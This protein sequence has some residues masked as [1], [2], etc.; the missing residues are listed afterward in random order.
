MDVGDNI[1]G[2]SAADSTV[3][4]ALARRLGI[5]RYL[6]TLYDPEAVGALSGRRRRGHRHAG[7]RGQDRP[8]RTASRWRSPGGSA[9]ATDGRYEDP[10]PT[11]GG[12]R[13]FDGGPTV[14]LETTDEHTLVLMSERVG[15]TSIQQMYAAGVRPETRQVVVAKGVVSPAPR[16]RAPSPPRSSSS[17]RPA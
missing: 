6:Q 10:G 8:E 11:H 7:G 1:G 4:L 17:T 12:Q 3:L 2:G 15:N 9:C 5:R 16:L 13:F 14:V